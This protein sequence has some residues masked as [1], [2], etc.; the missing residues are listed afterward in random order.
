MELQGLEMYY[1][2][3]NHTSDRIHHLN[4]RKQKLYKTF[5]I[6]NIES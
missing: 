4:I 5:K 3:N 1:T 2:M 6:L